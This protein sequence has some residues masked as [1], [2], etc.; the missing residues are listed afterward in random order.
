MGIRRAWVAGFA[1]TVILAIMLPGCSRSKKAA[2]PS[3]DLLQTDPIRYEAAIYY[4]PQPTTDPEV[5]FRETL[6]QLAPQWKSIKQADPKRDSFVYIANRLTNV[7]KEYPPPNLKSLQYFGRGLSAEQAE[8]LQS[9]AVVYV[10]DFVYPPAER[11][12]ALRSATTIMEQLARATGG[13]IW[14]E[15]TREVFTPDEWKRLR[16]G[17]WT[18]TVPLVESHVTIHLYEESGAVRAVTLGMS[19]FGLPD[20]VIE[21]TAWSN[22]KSVCNTINTLAQSLIENSTLTQPGER[23][24]VLKELQ[25]ARARE[26]Q[27]AKLE[28]NATGEA[29]IALSWAKPQEGDAENRL[30]Q[31]GF[32]HYDGPDDHARQ[33]A[34]FGSLFGW[35]DSIKRIKSDDSQLHAASQRARAQLPALRQSFL[36]GF[37]PGEYLL[38]KAPFA[39]PAGGREWMWVQVT[40]WKDDRIEG[41]LKNEPYHIPTLHSG[42]EVTVSEGDI[43]DY[44]YYKA[45]G[46]QSGNETGAIIEKMEGSTKSTP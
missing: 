24:L 23:R 3:G 37:P 32:G 44:I 19:K 39:I 34:L 28:A 16:L 2:A 11:F 7:A 31:I 12:N 8:Q 5:A 13:L 14:D 42:Q 22:K 27:L 33:D 10:V 26:K 40:K 1:I 43:F 17:D 30:L 46:S 35:E 29:R 20:L 36:K 25:N 6:A 9:C 15:A 18:E 21:N 4:L 38:L 45:D 41:L